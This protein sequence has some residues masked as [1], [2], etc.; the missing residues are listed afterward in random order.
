MRCQSSSSLIWKGS[1]PSRLH[2]LPT[3]EL[4]R[5]WSTFVPLPIP[6]PWGHTLASSRAPRLTVVIQAAIQESRK[7]NY[8]SRYVCGDGLSQRNTQAGY[9][10]SSSSSAVM[11][12]FSLLTLPLYWNTEE[13]TNWKIHE[14]IFA[15]CLSVC[16]SNCFTLSEPQMSLCL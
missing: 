7:Q 16:G 8:V 3:G 10:A 5:W 13:T 14:S 11:H 15:F 4:K 2:D 12:S 6:I 1:K 9:L